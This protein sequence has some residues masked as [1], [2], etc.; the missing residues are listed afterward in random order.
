LARFLALKQALGVPREFENLHAL[1]HVGLLGGFVPLDLTQAA[2]LL[3][4]PLGG[5]LVKEGGVHTPV[6]LV[7]IHGV[8]A[9]TEPLSSA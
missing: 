5:H 8:D 3:L 9:V 2:V 7:E 6:K 4:A 1:V